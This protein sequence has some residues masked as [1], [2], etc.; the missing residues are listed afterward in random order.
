[1]QSKSISA[2]SVE[3][4]ETTLNK[5]MADR[6]TPTLAIVFTSI[7]QD[8]KAITELLSKNDIN[9]FGA[10]S[11]V[12]FVNGKQSEGETAMLLLD[13]NRQA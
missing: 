4:I 3:E 7:K 1:M 10:T 2:G 12:E 8:R 13:L 5:L 11:C 9:V 6:F